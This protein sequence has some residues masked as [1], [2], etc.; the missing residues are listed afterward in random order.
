MTET[1][2]QSEHDFLTIFPQLDAFQQQ[3]PIHQANPF[4]GK[5]DSVWER[6]AARYIPADYDQS[7]ED[8]QGLA[9]VY[10][11]AK[12]GKVYGI[13]YIGTAG[14]SAWHYR[15]RSVEDVKRR[16]AELFAS[17]ADHKKRMDDYR[18]ERS[19]PHTFKVGDIIY[20]SWGYDQTNIDW[21]RIVKTSR[22][23]VWIQPIAAH[24]T[25]TAFMSGTSSPHVDTTSP[26][27][28]K[29]GYVDAKGAVEKH[30]ASGERVT[31]KFG[32]GTKWDGKPKGCS[33]YA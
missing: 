8:P 6:L 32:S 25:E 13:A 3:P 28:E 18:R 22:N 1:C 5:P 26:T 29:W 21:Y 27:P 10:Y 19:Q 11:G 30:K 12:N 7:I 33:W 2:T 20:N 9:V 14:K 23:F 4:S 15:F 31:M 17:L 24:I 16:A